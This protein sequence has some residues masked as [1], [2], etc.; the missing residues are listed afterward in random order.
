MAII[1]TGNVRPGLRL[2][3]HSSLLSDQVCRSDW[4]WHALLLRWAYGTVGHRTL[5]FESR[6]FLAFRRTMRDRLSFGRLGAPKKAAY[7]GCVGIITI[8]P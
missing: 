5:V 4:S 8:L 7:N 3:E 2:T 1:W 6:N